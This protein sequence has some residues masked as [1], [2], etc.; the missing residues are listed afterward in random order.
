MDEPG[1]DDQM[2]AEQRQAMADRLAE[3]EAAMDAEERRTA[4]QP[5]TG[6]DGPKYA[7]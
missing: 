7:H 6:R 2:T 1:S 5:V 3:E 4:E